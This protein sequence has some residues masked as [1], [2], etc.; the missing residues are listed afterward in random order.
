MIN[1][2]ADDMMIRSLFMEWKKSGIK[3][4]ELTVQNEQFS[5]EKGFILRYTEKEV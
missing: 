5:K 4:Q 3:R 1:N 2:D